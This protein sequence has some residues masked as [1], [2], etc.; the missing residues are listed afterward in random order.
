MK[1]Q[2]VE[3][4]ALTVQETKEVAMNEVKGTDRGRGCLRI[5]RGI[6]FSGITEKEVSI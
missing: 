4:A 1:I 5:G 2:K 3:D 6:S